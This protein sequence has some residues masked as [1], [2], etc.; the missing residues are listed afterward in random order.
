MRRNIKRH[1]TVRRGVSL[2]WYFLFFNSLNY[3]IINYISL[4][5][6]IEYDKEFNKEERESISRNK[7]DAAKYSKYY[8]N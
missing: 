1:L 8:E 7:L 2:Y 4:I 3:F 5:F 6:N